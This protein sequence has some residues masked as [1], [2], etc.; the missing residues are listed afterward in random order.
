MN[1]RPQ[2][3]GHR[4][5]R[6]RR[7]RLARARYLAELLRWGDAETAV[8]LITPLLVL[9][10]DPSAVLLTLAATYCRVAS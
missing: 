4:T 8:K 10:I 2:R 9:T 6:R 5:A 3:R 7:A 1:A